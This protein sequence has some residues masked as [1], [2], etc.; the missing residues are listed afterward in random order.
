VSGLRDWISFRGTHP[1]GQRHRSN[2]GQ[3]VD[4]LTTPH[5]VLVKENAPGFSATRYRDHYVHEFVGRDGQLARFE[6][7]APSCWR[8]SNG[9]ELVTALVL[10][11]DGHAPDWA[12]LGRTGNLIIGYTTWSHSESEPRWRLVVPFAEP[13]AVEHWSAVHRA[14]VARFDPR[15]DPRCKDAARLFFLHA[16]PPDRAHLAETRLLEGTLWAPPGIDTDP[17][18][19]RVPVEP[20][21]A[22]GDPDLPF[23]ERTLTFFE[24]G[25]PIGEQRGRALAA[26]RSLLARGA[27]I[28]ETIERVWQGLERSP[29]DPGKRAWARADAEQIVHDLAQRAAPPLQPYER[30]PRLRPRGSSRRVFSL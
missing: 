26:T 5:C 20:I 7:N 4:V 22:A 29:Q 19:E 25:V 15:A 12:A 13:I 17:P 24:G 9:V 30:I 8:S 16:S 28:E 18:A 3:L 1:R 14:G 6:V 2:L 27:P 10:D 23:G 11:D 21:S